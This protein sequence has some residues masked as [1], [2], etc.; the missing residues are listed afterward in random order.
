M[1]MIDVPYTPPQDKPRPGQDRKPGVLR[2]PQPERAPQ[3]GR[4]PRTDPEDERYQHPPIVDE[5]TDAA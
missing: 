5:P 3:P 1:I 2:D 4:E